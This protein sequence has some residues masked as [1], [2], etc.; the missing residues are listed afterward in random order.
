MI[1]K[2]VLAKLSPT[3]EEGTIVKWNKK[4]GDPV[5]VGDV[6]AEIETD[7]ANMEMEALAAGVLRKILVP[8]GGKAP[9]GSLI[10][11]I[12]DANEDIAGILSQATAAAPA[13]TPP[14]PAP[15]A[16]APTASTPPPAAAKPA[17]PAPPPAVPAPKPAPAVAAPA[18]ATAPPAS[19]PAPAPAAAAPP[20]APR[21]VVAPPPPSGAPAPVTSVAPAA[22]ADHGDGRVKAS[23][24][25]RAMAARENV[26]LGEVSGSG[27]AGRIVK[28]DIETYVA[29][30][31]PAPAAGTAS[32][33]PFP[34]VAAGAELPLSNMRKT[35]AR[36]LSESAFTAPHFYVTVEID[37]G[38]AVALREQLLKGENLKISYNDLVVKACARALTRFPM[39]NASW[40]GDKIVTH[41]EVH[42]GVAVAIPDGLITPV[43]RNADQKSVLA[44]ATEIKDL[45]G[46]ARE[47]KLRPEEYMGS[48]FTISNLGM[49]DVEEFT[50]IINPPDSAILA[51]GSVRKVPVVAGD[52]VAIGHRMKVTMSSDHRVVDGAMAAQFLA[53]VRR[54]LENP[55]SLLV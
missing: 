25:A 27:P 37:M 40:G 2:V 51:V 7:K 21:P 4:E 46:R 11:V 8:A 26:P 24:L 12:A 34:S 49:F 17:S 43:V 16:P 5:K 31:R 45:A 35:I 3:M 23:P 22:A 30:P 32:V 33:V 41:G 48:T 9:V 42:I 47:K 55:V 53:E 19:R 50:A 14:A 13:A 29:T 10:G 52:A 18:P 36:R 1:S 39:V 38:A 28:R 6:L 20:P 15:P 44:I 54:L